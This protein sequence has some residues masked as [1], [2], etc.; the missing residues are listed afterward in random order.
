M[1]ALT[2]ADLV[3]ATQLLCDRPERDW[4]RVMA[5]V[6]AEAAC[7]DAFRQAQGHPH[8]HLG[9][10]TLMAASLAHAP[11]VAPP[12]CDPRF[13]VALAFVLHSL[14]DFP[15][16]PVPAPAYMHAHGSDTPSATQ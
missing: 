8:P 12:V 4:G 3:A 6:L 2:L 10:G 1:R 7:A 9:A 14:R 13:L 11:R 15:L 5:Q 16:S